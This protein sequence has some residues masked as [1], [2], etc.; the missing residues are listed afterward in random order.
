MHERYA[1]ASRRATGSAGCS[2]GPATSAE[3]ISAIKQAKRQAARRP[4]TRGFTADTRPAA[5]LREICIM[6]G[7][8]RRCTLTGRPRR[9]SQSGSARTYCASN[10]GSPT[11]ACSFTP[12]ARASPPDRALPANQFGV[13]R[14]RPVHL[15]PDPPVSDAVWFV[16]D[17]QRDYAALVLGF[18]ESQQQHQVM[19]PG[20]PRT[21][22]HTHYHQHRRRTVGQGRHRLAGPLDCS[23][24]MHEGLR[25]IIQHESARR[26]ARLAGTQPALKAAPRR[27]IGTK[28]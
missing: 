12:N 13:L 10:S 11:A 24:V 3:G 2:E 1:A 9:P 23:A 4:C 8:A 18:A 17:D 26:L 14:S 20:L 7:K 6:T 19:L 21:A 28:A 5:S 27:R 16:V 22:K 25:A 15:C